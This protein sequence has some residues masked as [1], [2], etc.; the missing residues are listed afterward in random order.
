VSCTPSNSRRLPP[1]RRQVA[2]SKVGLA[3]T[4]RPARASSP[5][6]C[7]AKMSVR[8]ACAVEGRP[9]DCARRRTRCGRERRRRGRARPAGTPC[10]RN[11][12]APRPGRCWPGRSPGPRNRPPRRAGHARTGRSPAPPRVARR[13]PRLHYRP[14]GSSSRRPSLGEV[15]ACTWAGQAA[16]SQT[17]RVLPDGCRPEHSALSAAELIGLSARQLRRR[18]DEH[19]GLSPVTLRSV[20]RFQRFLRW[21]QQ[22]LSERGSLASAAADFGYTDQPHLARDCRRLAAQTPGSCASARPLQSS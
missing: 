13:S 2:G 14:T 10:S 7:Q 15:S 4:H 20:L 6:P 11:S 19:V 3:L 12:R 17:L 8:I 22:D 16:W 21:A 5:Y 1:A 18:F 9:S